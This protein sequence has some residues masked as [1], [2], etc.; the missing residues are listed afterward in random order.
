MKTILFFIMVGVTLLWLLWRA[1]R[2]PSQNFGS[3]DVIVPAFNE[4]PCIGQ[5]L[6]NLYFNPYVNRVICVNDGSTDGTATLLDKLAKANS[7]LVVVHQE[8]T[9]KGGAIMHGLLRVTAPYV[10][11]TDADTY[12][13]SGGP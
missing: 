5:S 2:G 8:N 11:L 6:R 4:E 12:V 1:R 9:G 10:F 3:I 13:P 7:R